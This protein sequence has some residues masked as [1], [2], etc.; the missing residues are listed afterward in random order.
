MEGF[1]GGQT[2][3]MGQ[4]HTAK[5]SFSGVLKH[6]CGIGLKSSLW[7]QKKN[8]RKKLRIAQKFGY[9][10]K[11]ELGKILSKFVDLMEIAF[12]G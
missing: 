8:R 5:L 12:F 10:N 6:I 3:E 2:N 7:C 9:F 4:I 11:F 1:L